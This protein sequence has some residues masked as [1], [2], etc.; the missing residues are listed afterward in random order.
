MKFSSKF[1]LPDDSMVHL[2]I[3]LNQKMLRCEL[4]MFC[5]RT[6]PAHQVKARTD[7]ISLL[8]KICFCEFLYFEIFNHMIA[9]PLAN[10]DLDLKFQ[11]NKFAG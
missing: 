11:T 1:K 7:T 2:K 6:L 10:L 5:C 8:L 9:L 4:F 3:I